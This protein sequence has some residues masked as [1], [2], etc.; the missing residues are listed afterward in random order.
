MIREQAPTNPG[1]QQI[2]VTGVVN[3]NEPFRRG[4][5]QP[6]VPNTSRSKDWI[7][8]AIALALVGGYIWWNEKRRS[9]EQQV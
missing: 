4:P 3:E 8:P 2:E 5:N 6:R 9:K 7:Y 1:G